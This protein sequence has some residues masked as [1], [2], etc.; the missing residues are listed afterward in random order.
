M[1]MNSSMAFKNRLMKKE[2]NVYL[3]VILTD[4]SQW[5]A[6]KEWSVYN[7]CGTGQ[8]FRKRMCVPAKCP[9]PYHRK[10]EGNSDKKCNE[11]CRPGSTM[12]RL[13]EL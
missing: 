11:Q 13:Y 12:N 1:P 7:R 5:G 8:S 2:S 9:D 10:C 3:P 4:K 6:W